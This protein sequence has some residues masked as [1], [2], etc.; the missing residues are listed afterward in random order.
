MRT[1]Q[2]RSSSICFRPC[3]QHLLGS[4]GRHAF[5]LIAMPFLNFK[6]P[7]WNSFSDHPRS[8]GKLPFL[9]QTRRC[10]HVMTKKS[11]LYKKKEGKSR[12]HSETK[13]GTWRPISALVT[14]MSWC[15]MIKSVLNL[16]SESLSTS[17][18]VS[19]REQLL[20]TTA[21]YQLLPVTDRKLELKAVPKI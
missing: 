8:W 20:A 11:H 1:P 18:L 15:C 10:S 3:R 6:T 16:P 2:S 17:Q 19:L 21:I 9:L 14:I 12:K 5:S 4:L 13:N 7:A